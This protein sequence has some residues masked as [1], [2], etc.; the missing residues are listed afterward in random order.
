MVAGGILRAARNV[1]VQTGF[2]ARRLRK[3]AFGYLKILF[4]FSRGTITNAA[5]AGG[6]HN[7]KVT[8]SA[9]IV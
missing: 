2:N 4:F 8:A 7:F 1:F 3:D 6:V 5:A 9:A